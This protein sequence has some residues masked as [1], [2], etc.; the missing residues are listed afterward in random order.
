[1][2]AKQNLTVASF[3]SLPIGQIG[4]VRLTLDNADNT[5]GR[6][7]YKFTVTRFR[8]LPVEACEL[9]AQ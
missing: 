4:N 3:S 7:D 5:T 2:Y 6:K 8:S 1:M 9:M